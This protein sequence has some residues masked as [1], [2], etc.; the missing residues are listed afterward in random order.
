MQWA[1]KVEAL[2]LRRDLFEFGR[3]WSI[4]QTGRI[5]AAHGDMPE[6]IFQADDRRSSSVSVNDSE[7][8]KI[9]ELTWEI[10]RITTDLLRLR[11]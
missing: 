9:G 10:S 11:I 5:S 2:F 8:M 3:R 6:F 7:R 1:E 4:D